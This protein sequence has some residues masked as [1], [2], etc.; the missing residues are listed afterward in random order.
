LCFLLCSTVCLFGCV[1]YVMT[2]CAG[3][4]AFLHMNVSST[5]RAVGYVAVTYWMTNANPAASVFFAFLSA[6]LLHMFVMQVGTRRSARS[7]LQI[8]LVRGGCD[9]GGCLR[10]SALFGVSVYACRCVCACVHVALSVARR[11]SGVCDRVEHILLDSLGARARRPWERSWEPS[12]LT[13]RPV[14]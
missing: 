3:T 10:V 11:P 2:V 13:R 8:F 6:I 12:S 4:N 1:V 5:R 9:C 7:C 14:R